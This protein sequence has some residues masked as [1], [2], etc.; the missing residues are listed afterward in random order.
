MK[1]LILIVCALVSHGVFADEPAYT[2]T[3]SQ[4]PNR[5][6]I[7][8]ELFWY[9]MSVPIQGVEVKDGIFFGGIKLGYEYLKPWACYANLEILSAASGNHFSADRDDQKLP[10]YPKTGFGSFDI[11]LGY[12]LAP[13]QVLV[14]PYLGFGG[15]AVVSG[16]HKGFQE[17]IEYLSG[18]LKSMWSLN[19]WCG[20]GVN[21]KIFKSVYTEQ[22]YRYDDVSVKEIDRKWGGEV[23]LPVVLHPAKHCDLQF[24]PYFLDLA[25]GQK[26]LIFGSRFLVGVR[27]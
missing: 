17:V 4:T 9:S 7:G 18:G 26:Q 15:Y 23:G 16:H 3:Y 21:A 25:F 8:P 11:R 24:E 13:S 10:N 27:F 19:Q 6:Y 2:Q 1:K 20:L 22:K 12:T 14:T 5:I